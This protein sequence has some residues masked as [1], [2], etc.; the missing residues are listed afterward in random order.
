[1]V[2]IVHIWQHWLHKQLFVQDWT[3]LQSKSTGSTD[4]LLTFELKTAG[5][6]SFYALQEAKYHKHQAIKKIK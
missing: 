2:H 1:M 6:T 5:S 4:R 3:L